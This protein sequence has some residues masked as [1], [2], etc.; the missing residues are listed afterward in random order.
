MLTPAAL[1]LLLLAYDISPNLHFST[2]YSNLATLASLLL[3][4]S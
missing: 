3:E 2:I 1:S 4:H